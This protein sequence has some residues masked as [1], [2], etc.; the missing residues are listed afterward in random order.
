MVGARLAAVQG[1]RKLPAAKPCPIAI[2]DSQLAMIM[3]ACEPIL[4]ADRDPFLRALAH[5]LQ[6]EPELG[7]GVVG[8]AIRELQREFWRPPSIAEEPRSR[9]VVGE[10]IA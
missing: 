6:G 5:R 4:P 2:S 8:R 7:D 9:R 10:P 3:R 1:G